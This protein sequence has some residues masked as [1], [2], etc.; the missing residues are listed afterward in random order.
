MLRPV[1]AC[2]GVRAERNHSIHAC[3]VLY[4]YTQLLGTSLT[5]SHTSVQASNST[6][7]FLEEPGST[8]AASVLP[9]PTAPHPE[10]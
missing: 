10:M 2:G 3:T 4:M 9:S 5:V 6:S 1:R 8:L 7:S